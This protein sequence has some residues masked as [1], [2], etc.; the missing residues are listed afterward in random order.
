[1]QP[2]TLG[3]LAQRVD[4]HLFGPSDLVIHAAK[5][6]REAGP[7]EIT[8]ADRPRLSQQAEHCGASAVI[9]SASF[10]PP[11]IPHIAVNDVVTAF[12]QI[13][14][15]FNPPSEERIRGVSASAHV[16]RSARIGVGVRV[17]PG[18]TIG[19]HVVIGDNSVIHAGCHVM[20]GCKIGQEV[21]LF[22]RVVLYEDTLVG[23]RVIIHAG[24]VIGAY[25][26]GYS[27]LEGR[28]HLSA[29][30]GNVELHDDVEIG[31][32]TTIDRGTYGPTVIGEGTKVDNLV[33]IAHNCRIGRH[34]L[35]CSQVGIAGSSVTG[36][37][38]AMAGQ[39][40]VRDHVT[41]G[42]TVQVGAQAGVAGDIA[43]GLQVLGT[44]AKPEREAIQEMMSLSRLPSV[45]KRLRE[46]EREI[47]KLR[48]ALA[49]E[50]SAESNDE[51]GDDS[52][53]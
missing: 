6:L 27:T 51:V 32:N 46:M 43:P 40:G 33:M 36:D 44:P 11:R 8:F 41:I 25:G 13:V 10:E 48:A 37:Y 17:G 53:A 31:A 22:P 45:R 26:F 47:K 30:L 42:N 20:A 50:E 14:E 38:V 21:T 52:A 3:D 12:T 39:V 49:P 15:L 23:D 24:A 1:M 29:Q 9:T 18:A 2:I 28:H 34:N 16:S 7:G 5:T 4:G 19:E 35:L